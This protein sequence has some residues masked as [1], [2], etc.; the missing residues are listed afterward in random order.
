MKKLLYFY[1]E[2]CPDCRRVSPWVDRI[3]ADGQV[4]CECF[5]VWNSPENEAR[6]KEYSAWFTSAYGRD[7]IVPAL[8]DAAGER[9]LCDP[10]TFDELR[11]W[12]AAG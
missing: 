7:T 3:E 4:A 10:R 11:E 12:V 1:G 8:V 2:G 9:V 6:K 5:E